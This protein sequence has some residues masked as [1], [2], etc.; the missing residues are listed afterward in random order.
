MNLV[1]LKIDLLLEWGEVE[2]P[3]EIEWEIYIEMNVEERVF[4]IHRV[5]FPVEA[6]ILL[7][8]NV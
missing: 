5:K 7:I 3:S 8:A 2:D 1:F 4:H 6:R